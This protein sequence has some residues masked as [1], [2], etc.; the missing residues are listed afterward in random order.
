M[1]RSVSTLMTGSI[2]YHVAWLEGRGEFQDKGG[3]GSYGKES[4]SGLF[5]KANMLAWLG[6]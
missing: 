2:H 1:K 5:G 3:K 4:C 6:S